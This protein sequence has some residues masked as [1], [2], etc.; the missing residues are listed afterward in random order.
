MKT[1]DR[2]NFFIAIFLVHVTLLVQQRRRN[3]GKLL[4]MDLAKLSLVQLK[5]F[6]LLM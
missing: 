4:V 3:L 1:E 5:M 2:P 6:K